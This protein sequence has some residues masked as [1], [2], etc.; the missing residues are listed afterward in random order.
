ML[1][2][3]VLAFDEQDRERGRHR[4]R[5]SAARGGNG[6]GGNGSGRKGPPKRRGRSLRA[7][8]VT[9]ILLAA[10]GAG[11]WFG[12]G[13]VRD[14][15]TAPDYTSA[16]TGEVTVQVRTGETATDNA[17][18]LYNAGVVKSTKAFTDAAKADPHGT[19]IQPGT[20][21]LR[22]QIRAKD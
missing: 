12:Y 7:L 16:G 18:T 2:D 6:G 20:Y 17:Q 19:E 4:H 8:L 10:L 1:D 21:Q 15:F 11:G 3:L 5:R 14:F 13:K 22:Q 9:L